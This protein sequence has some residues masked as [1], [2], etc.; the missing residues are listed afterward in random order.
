MTHVSARACSFFQHFNTIFI[1]I[2]ILSSYTGPTDASTIRTAHP[3][4]LA[5][6]GRPAHESVI[7]SRTMSDE[8]S[9]QNQPEDELSDE[10][11]EQISGGDGNRQQATLT[12]TS[13]GETQNRSIYD[14]G[15]DL[16]SWAKVD[17]MS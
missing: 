4:P 14:K 6:P 3:F 7:R 16:G 11:L 10:Q 13:T 8:R 15:I 12:A 1:V 17:G 2:T 5:P 9:P